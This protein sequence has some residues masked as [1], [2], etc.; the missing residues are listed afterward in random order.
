VLPVLLWLILLFAA[1]A[2]LPRG[3][4]HEEETHTATA[5]RLAA[6]PSAVFAGKLLY[7]LTLLLG[8]RAGLR[9]SSWPMVQLP[10]AAPLA[11]RRARRRRPG[12][13]RRARWSRRW[14]PRRR[15]P[16]RS[17]PSWPSRCCAPAC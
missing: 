6:R 1:A 4:V 8:P 2:G 10:V 12:S 14:W 9:R 7:N 16:R 15:A 3:F 11:R 17:S 5:L 13:R